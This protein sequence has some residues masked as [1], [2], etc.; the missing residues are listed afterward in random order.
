MKLII[1][2]QKVFQMEWNYGYDYASCIFVASWCNK[3]DPL[4]ELAVPFYQ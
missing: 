1:D 2:L 3:S 4:I